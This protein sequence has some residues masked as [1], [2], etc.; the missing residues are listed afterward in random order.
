MK[1]QTSVRSL[2]KPVLHTAGWLLLAITIWLFSSMASAQAQTQAP[3]QPAMPALFV[4][5]TS[6]KALVPTTE[7][8]REGSRP[9]SEPV[10][11]TLN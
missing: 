11:T 3:A 7:A 10:S 5:D 8:F 4:E 9:S 1:T 2:R 6:P